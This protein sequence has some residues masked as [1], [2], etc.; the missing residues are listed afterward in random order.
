MR[1]ELAG[2]ND[3]NESRKTIHS[4]VEQVSTSD[5]VVEVFEEDRNECSP[6]NNAQVN[7]LVGRNGRLF[8]GQSKILDFETDTHAWLKLSSPEN[9]R[10]IEMRRWARVPA[11]LN[12]HYHL[13]SYSWSQYQ[14]NTLD[15]GGGGLLFSS[16]HIVDPKL[17]LEVGIELPDKRLIKSLVEVKRCDGINTRWG[18]RFKIGCSF[19]YIKE[20]HRDILI[21]YIFDKQRD[22]IKK[23]LLSPAN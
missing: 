13:Q 6:I 11:D 10:R 3:N 20:D 5:F 21:K 9:I 2:A 8:T 18:D 7:L 12:I 4:I 15:I 14:S 16:K 19:Q 17:M 1:I 23:G 22:M